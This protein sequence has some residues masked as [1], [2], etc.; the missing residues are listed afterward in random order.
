MYEI[1]RTPNESAEDQE[2]ERILDVLEYA[3]D[4]EVMVELTVATPM[5]DLR[6]NEVFI[7]GMEDNVVYISVSPESPVMP[8]LF[9]SIKD[10][11]L[12]KK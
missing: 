2:R 8:I 1:L 5:G 10:A 11:K 3:F 12:T 9:A 7:Q 4:K 6:T